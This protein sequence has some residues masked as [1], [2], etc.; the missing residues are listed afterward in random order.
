MYGK[1]SAAFGE[2]YFTRDMGNGDT[3]CRTYLSQCGEIMAELRPI[4]GGKFR[5]TIED[6][7]GD[8]I[9]SRTVDHCRKTSEFHEFMD[10]YMN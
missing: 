10:Y 9:A 1:W 2:F 7:N 8:R 6:V 3:T 5:V 4:G